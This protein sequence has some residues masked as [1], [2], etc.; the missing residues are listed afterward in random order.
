MSL[1]TDKSR[2]TG[3]GSRGSRVNWLMGHVGHGSKSVTHCHL[4]Y[5]QRLYIQYVLH[6]LTCKTYCHH[7]LACLSVIYITILPLVIKNYCHHKPTAITSISSYRINKW[8]RLWTTWVSPRHIHKSYKRVFHGGGNIWDKAAAT[9]LRW[10]TIEQTNEQTDKW[11]SSS[12]KAPNL[13]HELTKRISSNSF[14]T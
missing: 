3:H 10:Q 5:R 2:V 6:V 11:T 9:R 4:W 14:L 13:R 12:R 7:L 1:E 8:A